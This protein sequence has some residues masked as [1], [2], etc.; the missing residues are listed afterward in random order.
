VA[1]LF[2]GDVGS[3]PIGLLT[4]WLLI[5]LAEH[6]LAAAVLL[7]LYYLADATVTLLRRLARGERITQAHRGHYY[8][9]A[10]DAGMSVNA[11]VTRVFI[12]NVVLAGLAWATLTASAG[13]QA[14]AL[15][16]GGVIVATLLVALSRART[17]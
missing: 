10:V 8:Q 12:V 4:G 17:R 2:L 1:R 7:P 6:H 9:Q 3:L 15:L 14:L 13:L 11:V 5:L 16:C